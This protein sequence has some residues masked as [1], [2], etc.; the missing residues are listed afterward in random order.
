MAYSEHYTVQA[1]LRAWA[2]AKLIAMTY[3]AVFMVV[4]LRL[5]VK[6]SI[7]MKTINNYKA[8]IERLEKL[9]SACESACQTAIMS[10]E[11]ALN[12]ID[13]ATLDKTEKAIL[14]DFIKRKDKAILVLKDEYNKKARGQA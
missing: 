8:K 11:N 14:N 2:L 7:L 9:A 12:G 5:C 6:R 3:K 1:R 4:C 10:L 13:I